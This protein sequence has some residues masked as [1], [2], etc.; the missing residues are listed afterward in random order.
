MPGSPPEAGIHAHSGRTDMKGTLLVIIVALALAVT[1]TAPPAADEPS[2]TPL[3]DAVRRATETFK[4]VTAATSAGY[5]AFLGCV[6]GPQDGAMGIH[7]V[8]GT[9]VGDGQ[10]D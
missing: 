10:L 8:N 5:A 2:H 3:V 1:A 9:L 7:F 4:D 6:S